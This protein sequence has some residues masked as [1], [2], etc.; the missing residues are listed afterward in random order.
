MGKPGAK[1]HVLLDAHLDQI[2]M[3][4]TEIDKDGFLMIDRCGGID[5]RTL[6]GSAV[7]IYGKEILRGI[8]CNTPPHLSSGGQD[9]VPAV[10][11]LAV[12]VGLTHDEAEELVQPGDRISIAFEQQKLLNHRI[13]SASLD[14]RAGCAALIRCA[15]LLADKP[16]DCECTILLSTR[17]E[18]GGQGAKTGTFG[19]NPTQAIA[20]DVSFA[21][22]PGVPS[23]KCG[24]LGGGP[25][26]GAAPILDKSMRTKLVQLAKQLK[27]PYEHDVMGGSTGTNSDGIACTRAGVRTALISIPLRYMHT[28]V[29]VIDVQDVEHTARLMAAYIQEVR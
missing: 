27:I 12:D 13:S 10:D 19:V 3:V 22:Q 4:V 14:D 23:A 26:I 16:L 18:V 7:T 9:K 29:E 20:V 8:I 6:P 28:P 15:Q 2:G 17:E 24:T 1:E 5:R 11:K 25:M 21:K